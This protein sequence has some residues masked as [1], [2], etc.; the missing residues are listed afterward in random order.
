MTTK[1]RVHEIIKEQ[2]GVEQIMLQDHQDVRDDLGADSLDKVEIILALEEAFA[3]IIS[4]EEEAEAQTV[5]QLVTLCE[6]L[7]LERE[8]A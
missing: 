3:I 2:L 7:I 6:K 8:A 5:G 4:D 1:E